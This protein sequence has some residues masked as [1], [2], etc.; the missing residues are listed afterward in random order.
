MTGSY[1]M[2]VFKFLGSWWTVFQCGCTIFSFLP[3][4]HE[5]SLF[6]ILANSW[7]GPYFHFVSNRCVLLS[8][9][10][11]IWIC[12]ITKDA[13]RFENMVYNFLL[14]TSPLVDICTSNPIFSPSWQFVCS[15]FSKE[16][17]SSTLTSTMG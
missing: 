7:Y 17:I 9:V 14:D 11:L 6:P 15:L 5:G 12:L 2:H 1:G 10:A 13:E 8:H 3:P 4:V 16:Q